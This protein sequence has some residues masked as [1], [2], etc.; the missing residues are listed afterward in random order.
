MSSFLIIGKILGKR[1]YM[2]EIVYEI[3]DNHKR[4]KGYEKWRE[5]REK[6]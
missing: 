4:N 6:V 3:F 1:K 5:G 2:F